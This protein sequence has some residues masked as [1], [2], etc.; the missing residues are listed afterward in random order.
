MSTYRLVDFKEPDNDDL[1]QVIT[2]YEKNEDGTEKPGTTLEE[3]LK[4]SI[5]RLQDLN[6]R[7]GCRENSV[8]ITKMQE[9]LMWLEERTKD[10]VKR[11]VE[12]QHAA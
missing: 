10:R 12:G 7:F 8:A 11:G 3:M 1:L 2:F 4:V 6:S 5:G 9:A